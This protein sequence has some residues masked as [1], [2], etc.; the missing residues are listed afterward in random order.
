MKQSRPSA[1]LLKTGRGRAPGEQRNIRHAAFRVLES[2]GE[3]QQVID[4]RHYYLPYESL[5]GREGELRIRG[6]GHVA[7]VRDLMLLMPAPAPSAGEAL[8]GRWLQHFPRLDDLEG[9]VATAA[10][11]TAE[12]ELSDAVGA[13]RAAVIQ[14]LRRLE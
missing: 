4:F 13:A 5:P 11:V 2:L 6:Y 12:R 3:I 14:V 1:G 9:D 7:M 8:H 10:A